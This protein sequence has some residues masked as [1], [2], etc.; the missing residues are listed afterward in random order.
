MRGQSS[1]CGKKLA[2]GAKAGLHRGKVVVGL[3][4][5]VAAGWSPN[6]Y[7]HRIVPDGPEQQA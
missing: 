4:R 7:A 1:S 3:D 5:A 2:E 6:G